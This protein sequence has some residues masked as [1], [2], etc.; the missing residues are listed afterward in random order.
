MTQLMY[1]YCLRFGKE[2][3]LQL[4]QNLN[5]LL[6]A[7][8]ELYGSSHC[9]VPMHSCSCL[10]SCVLHMLP[11]N[12]RFAPGIWNSNYQYSRCLCR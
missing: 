2:R 10:I 3:L 7:A 6:T 11:V 12:A 4:G 9:E 8:K 1:E 5:R